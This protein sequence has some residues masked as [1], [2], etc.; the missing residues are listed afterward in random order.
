MGSRSIKA[1]MRYAARVDANHTEIVGALRAAGAT[2]HSMAALG[3]G[4]PDLLVGHAG[5]TAL[6]E[7]KDGAKIPSKR[8]L[9]PDQQ[10]FHANW[11]GGTL[12]VVDSAEAALRVL[13]LMESS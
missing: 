1:S 4:F 10:D 13:K 3:G 5:K 2:V 6:I 8:K 11:K 9:T 12:A 7:V